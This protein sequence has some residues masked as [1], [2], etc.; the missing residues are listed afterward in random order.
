MTIKKMYTAYICEKKKK[1]NNKEDLYK[2][3]QSQI[4]EYFS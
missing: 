1:K 4:S 3:E 2:T